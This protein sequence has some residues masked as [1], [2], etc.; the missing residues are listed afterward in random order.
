MGA[1]QAS[2]VTWYTSWPE[3]AGKTSGVFHVFADTLQLEEN[4][5][6]YDKDLLH[7]CA[8]LLGTEKHTDQCASLPSWCF[9]NTALYREEIVKTPLSESLHVF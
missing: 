4:S 6:E 7:G 9:E 5:N 1:S 2:H 8:R 3:C